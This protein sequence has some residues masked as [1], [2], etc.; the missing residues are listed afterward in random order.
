MVK[1]GAIQA[2]RPDRV[3]GRASRSLAKLYVT[4]FATKRPGNHPIRGA[5]PLR[6]VSNDLSTE[7]ASPA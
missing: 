6:P 7:F 3:G 4:P 5:N 2:R 1:W